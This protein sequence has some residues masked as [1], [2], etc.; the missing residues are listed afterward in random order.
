MREKM[1]LFVATGEV[2]SST[3]RAAL[4][5]AERRLVAELKA[6]GLSTK[7]IYTFGKTTK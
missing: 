5:A 6:G 3:N 2:I 1:I 7:R 4:R